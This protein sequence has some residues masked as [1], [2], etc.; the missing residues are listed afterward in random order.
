[1]LIYGDQEIHLVGNGE[2]IFLEQEG[3][4]LRRPQW[5]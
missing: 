2:A 4:A 3:K 5:T 1:M